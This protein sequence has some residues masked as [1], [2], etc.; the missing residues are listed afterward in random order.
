M[1]S[2]FVSNSFCVFVH[3]FVVNDLISEITVRNGGK[4]E[5]AYVIFF[6]LESVNALDNRNFLMLVRFFMIN[7]LM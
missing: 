5:L 4:N 7:T 1:I 6:R 2:C 3:M